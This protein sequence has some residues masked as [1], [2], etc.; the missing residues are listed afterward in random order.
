MN[1]DHSM[2][3]FK[4]SII[5]QHGGLPPAPGSGYSPVKISNSMAALLI[6]LLGLG[7]RLPQAD[8]FIGDLAI[9]GRA[10][11]QL[12]IL[13]KTDGTNIMGARWADFMDPFAVWLSDTLQ[14]EEYTKEEQDELAREFFEMCIIGLA[15]P[16]T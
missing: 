14:S 5:P 11:T 3:D 6:P 12:L 2:T 4:V 9:N 1:K 16:S 15:T 7:T 8:C 13:K 10:F